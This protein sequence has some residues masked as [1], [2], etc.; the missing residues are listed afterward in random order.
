MERNPHGHGSPGTQGLSADSWRP[1]NRSWG[2]SGTL[3]Q[4]Y[5]PRVRGCDWTLVR[6]PNRRP[7]GYPGGKTGFPTTSVS[8]PLEL[9]ASR[10]CPGGQGLLFR[11]SS[12]TSCLTH[13]LPTKV[14]KN[15][16]QKKKKKAVLTES[17][18]VTGYK[19]HRLRHSLALGF[20]SLRTRPS[21][22]QG[23][24]GLARAQSLPLHLHTEFSSVPVC[25]TA[26]GSPLPGPAT[27]PA[28]VKGW[29]K[30]PPTIS[31]A[32]THVR[33]Y[34]RASPRTHTSTP[35]WLTVSPDHRKEGWLE[36]WP[37]G[38]G[39]C[40]PCGGRVARMPRGSHFCPP[41]GP[42]KLEAWG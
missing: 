3:C 36:R 17:S 42:R 9:E 31:H 38:V 28:L 7:T 11:S 10:A 41:R 40:A 30:Q 13:H 5:W 37:Q 23:R 35:S 2:S 19:E 33:T 34:V 20:E 32:R 1:W 27:G 25:S 21:S 24:E 4:L 15:K 22:T 8:V 12:E 29:D 39:V 14:A 16:N 6:S 26:G 18:H